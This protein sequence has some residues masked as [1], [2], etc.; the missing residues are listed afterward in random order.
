MSSILL[1]LFLYLV[2]TKLWHY[3]DRV[4][5]M[6]TIC[7]SI[8]FLLLMLICQVLAFERKSLT[9]MWQVPT[10]P[11]CQHISSNI[12]ISVRNGNNFRE[13]WKVNFQK[14]LSNDFY[15]NASMNLPYDNLSNG[16]TSASFEHLLTFRR[17]VIRP[18][19]CICGHPGGGVDC[20]GSFQPL[21]P[22][23][24]AG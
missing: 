17:T 11:S 12:S 20:R 9:R 22:A 1:L 6:S 4:W 21:L 3:G 10:Y 16:S 15:I 5:A 13:T 24:T 14:R 8:W 2:W 18:T 19:S 23:T 7:Y